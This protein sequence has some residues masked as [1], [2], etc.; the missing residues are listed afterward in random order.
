MTATYRAAPVERRL[1]AAS[2]I[3]L[4]FALMQ[5]CLIPTGHAQP[6]SDKPA[7][8]KAATNAEQPK[9]TIRQAIAK[10]MLEAEKLLKEKK[11]PEVLAQIAEAEKVEGKTPYEIYI[12]DR[13]RAV[14]ALG[15]GNDVLAVQSLESAFASGRV[16]MEET[17][18]FLDG[19]ARIY[20]RQ[21]EYK[22]AA[23]W[24]ARAANE[25]NARIE[26][27][28]LLGHSAHLTGDFATAKR[29]VAIVVAAGEQA[30]TAPPEDQLRL[31]ANAYLKTED[32]PGYVAV[33]E[34]LAVRYPKKDYWADLIYRVESK[35]GFSERLA[36]DVYRLKL[37]T[38]VLSEKSDFLEMATTTLQS[39]FPAEAQRVIDAGVAA[40]V[41]DDNAS[42]DSEKKLRASI[43]KELAEE[44]A[45]A[46]KANQPPPKGSI[47]LL[48][49]GFDAVIKGNAPKGLELMEAGLKA[50]DLRR[51]DEA[52]LRYGV[53]LVLAGQKP[54]AIETFKSVEGAD[55]AAALARIWGLYSGATAK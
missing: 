55:G 43:S 3:F 13:M 2:R 54:K 7:T 36:L 42:A 10:P 40:K 18:A 11:Y 20:Y 50:A 25:P 14:A 26:T 33:L 24:A 51:P 35:A 22:K 15:V 47:A 44:N 52:R 32:I 53:A 6:A 4:A 17:Y 30:G 45:R 37:I 12:L 31:L 34:K 48:N 23:M 39:G 38:G 41:L 5:L 1:V 9:E 29:E 16:P 27:R 8:E 21:K 49:N 46:A 19:M 28:L